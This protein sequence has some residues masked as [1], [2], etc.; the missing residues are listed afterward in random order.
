MNTRLAA[1][2]QAAFTLESAPHHREAAVDWVEWRE[3]A[4]LPPLAEPPG[5]MDEVSREEFFQ[6]LDAETV[7]CPMPRSEPYHS[8]WETRNG[9]VWGWSAPGWKDGGV[10]DPRRVYAVVR[11]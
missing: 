7:L 6:L 8:S 4:G 10:P 9:M 11:R 3:R 2:D 1:A 5:G